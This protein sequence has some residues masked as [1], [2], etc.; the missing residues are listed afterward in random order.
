MYCPEYMRLAGLSES[1]RQ[2]YAYIRLNEGKAG[3]S[4]HRYDE[5]VQEGYAALKATIKDLG[6]HKMHCPV[7]KNQPVK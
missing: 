2:A 5:L 3:L 1:K 4:K 7:C 6:L